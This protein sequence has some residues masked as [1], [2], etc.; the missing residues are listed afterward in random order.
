MS[1][2]VFTV[3]SRVGEQRF[4]DDFQE[5]SPAQITKFSPQAP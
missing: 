1:E 2:E 5:R 3:M 4:E